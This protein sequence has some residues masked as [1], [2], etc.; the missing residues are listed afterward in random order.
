MEREL[1][2]KRIRG[3]RLKKQEAEPYFKV[4]TYDADSKTLT[5]SDPEAESFNIET[6]GLTPSGMFILSLKGEIAQIKRRLS[7]RRA[8]LEGRSAIPHLGPLIE[9][10][11]KVE[12]T[13]KPPKVKP[14]TAFVLYKIFV[15]YQPNDNQIEA[16]KTALETPD[17]ALIQGPPGT[18]KTTVI[19]AIL[20]RLN[21]MADKRQINIKGQVL[22]TGSQHDVVENMINRRSLNGLPIPKI[23]KRSGA[24]ED[25]Y[26][27]FKKDLIDWCSKT[28]EK[29]RKKDLNIAGIEKEIKIK[30]LCLQYINAP[31]RMLAVNIAEN[32][33]S[34]DVTVIGENISRRAANIAKKLS[35]EDSL[36][37][38][39]DPLL[40]AVR[41]LRI[42]PESF[43]DDGPD[44][45]ADALEDLKNN[46]EKSKIEKSELDLLDKASLWRDN[47]PPPFLK[48]LAALKKKLLIR[49]TAPPAFR[50][51]KQ[52][53]EILTLA[54]EAIRKIKETGFS[55]KD[56]KSAALAEFLA[57]LEMNPYG[58]IDALSDYSFA[59]AAT[60]QQSVN[61][62][63]QEQKG[64]KS[65]STEHNM[66]YEYVIVDEAARVS[67]RDLMIPMAY[68]KRVIL[69]GDHRQLPHIIE[70]EVAR[71][72]EEA[73]T[74]EKE[75]EWLKKSMFQYLFSERLKVLEQKDGI[76]RHV[77]L[78]TQYRM[79]PLLGEFISRNFYERFDPSEKFNSVRPGSDFPHNLPDTDNKPAVWLDIPASKGRHERSGTSWIRPAEAAAIAK[80]LKTWM[81]SKEGKSLTFGVISFYKAQADRIRSN[82]KEITDD[83]NRLRVGTV[84]S[85]QGMEFDVVFLSMVRTLPG[86]WKPDDKD[87]EKQA[88]NIFGHLCL[89]N[90]LNV[91]MSRQK[92]LLVVAGDSGLLKGQLA[93]EFIPGLVDFFR[94]CR[95]NGKVIPC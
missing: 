82:L 26:D 18:G 88:R 44:R 46:I 32:I 23:G 16:I 74:G 22:L 59:F 33:A 3:K 39:A 53:D 5:V 83:D 95:E 65:G 54:D 77:T 14:L 81:N 35:L 49:F 37:P 62:L 42:L 72:M 17:I 12:P 94:L 52:S 21:E 92:R 55:A 43:A 70:D 89:Y 2:E 90:R 76:K 24:N 47:I 60:C 40:D 20:E 93:A 34:L 29:L 10:K 67:P 56:A 6:K 27:A 50:V 38:E 86:N 75:S 48:E 79:H 73:E 41:R 69:V 11:G 63:M 91:S 31:T 1:E 13:R 61:E 45:A 68:G 64:I 78:D 66:E 9:E 80:Q 28:A 25:D 58:M 7:A 87:R 19:A 8:I 4:S 85:F 84:D 36:N 71:Q 30:N 57:E 51:E 15:N